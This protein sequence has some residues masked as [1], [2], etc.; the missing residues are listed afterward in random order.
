MS[1]TEMESDNSDGS[2]ED[3]TS[4]AR[5][6]DSDDSDADEESDESGDSDDDDDRDDSTESDVVDDLHDYE[7][8]DASM[9]KLIIGI[10][11]RKA[12]PNP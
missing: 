3:Q 5:I 9:H 6:D 1:D 4:R 7:R 8:H 12:L 2:L 11:S 10:V